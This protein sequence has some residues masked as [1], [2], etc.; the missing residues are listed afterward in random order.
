MRPTIVSY[1][2]I[3]LPATYGCKRHHKLCT[4]ICDRRI[5]RREE[6]RR[7]TTTER[8]STH[9]DVIVSS[10]YAIQELQ[11]NPCFLFFPCSGGQICC[12]ENVWDG[13]Q[14]TCYAQKRP[15]L[16]GTCLWHY[17]VLDLYTILSSNN[18]IQFTD[19]QIVRSCLDITIFFRGGGLDKKL[20]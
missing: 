7:L 10:K 2:S 4:S 11:L 1:P 18:L 9:G 15:A 12:K 20:P 16:S 17:L 6:E 14:S 3:Y 19:V 13:M 5:I 8:W